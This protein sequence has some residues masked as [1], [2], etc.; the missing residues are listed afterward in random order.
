MP[1]I[2]E[3][4]AGDKV[5]VLLVFNLRQNVPGDAPL[6]EGVE[7]HVPFLMELRHELT[8]RVDNEMAVPTVDR[9]LHQVHQGRCLAGVCDAHDREV[10]RLDISLH[11]HARQGRHVVDGGF[12]KR[13][14]GL[15]SSTRLDDGPAKDAFVGAR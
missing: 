4:S 5:E 15:Q 8:A 10:G 13:P 11:Q 14:P 7:D 6:I 9:G 1:R 2:R 3:E 12:A